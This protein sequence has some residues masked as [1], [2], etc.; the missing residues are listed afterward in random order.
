MHPYISDLSDGCVAM[1][2]GTTVYFFFT[3][4]TIH[5]NSTKMFTI[6]IW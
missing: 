2:E 1:G 5:S 3:R 4:E 6:K